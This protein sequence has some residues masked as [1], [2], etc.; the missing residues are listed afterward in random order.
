MEYEFRWIPGYVNYYKISAY[1]DVA[2]FTRNKPRIMK[3]FETANGYIAVNLMIP[4][5][6]DNKVRQKIVAPLVLETFGTPPPTSQYRV[7]YKDG[8]TTNIHISNLEWQSKEDIMR[9]NINKIKH[10][11]VR[12]KPIPIVIF[13]EGRNHACKLLNHNIGYN[14]DSFKP[15]KEGYYIFSPDIFLEFYKGYKDPSTYGT[16]SYRQEKDLLDMF[17]I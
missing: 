4:S 5:N 9:N 7:K 6:R 15:S 14:I 16:V 17:N 13:T 11:I 12:R 10:M 2:S 1:G 8:D 3:T